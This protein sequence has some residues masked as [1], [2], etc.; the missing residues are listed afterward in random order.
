M[1]MI[2]EV[3]KLLIKFNHVIYGVFDIMSGLEQESN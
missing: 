2:I 3:I 1:G